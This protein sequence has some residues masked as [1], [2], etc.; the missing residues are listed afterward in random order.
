MSL[1]IDRALVSTTFSVEGFRV[2]RQVGLV[3]GVVVRS[4]SVVGSFGAMLQSLIG[5]RIGLWTHLAEQSREDAY[6]EMLKHASDLG[7]NGVIGVRYDAT[8]IAGGVQEVI[9][10]GTAVVLE[11][12]AP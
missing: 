7:A 10:Y 8:E 11:P 3:R 1:D 12:V 6:Q 4:R 5:G 2:A 9:A